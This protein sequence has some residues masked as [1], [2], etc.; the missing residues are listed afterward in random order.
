MKYHL[1]IERT[2]RIGKEFEADSDEE[3]EAMA[4]ELYKTTGNE[5]LSGY[6]EG[7]YALCDEKYRTIIDWD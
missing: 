2:Y 7:D 3:A 6:C 1:T 4:A 5:I